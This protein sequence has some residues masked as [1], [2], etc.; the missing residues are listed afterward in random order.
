MQVRRCSCPRALAA[1]SAFA[2]ATIALAIGGC[3][4][5]AAAPVAPRP[6]T[7]AFEVVTSLAPFAS[8]RVNSTSL[9]IDPR[10][11]SHLL[12]RV[13]AALSATSPSGTL[14]GQ[15][16]DPSAFPVTSAQP[17]PSS[18]SGSRVSLEPGRKRSSFAV[19]RDL[20]STLH[21]DLID[22]CRAP[23]G[24]ILPPESIEIDFR[25]D[26]LGRIERTSVRA[27][28][29]LPAHEPAARCMAR[30]IRASDARFSSSLG[31]SSSVIHA[32]VPSED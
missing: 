24:D 6:S 30:V 31:E 4:D 5:D 1:R 13:P 25:V 3:T 12:A 18:T 2:Y 26:S 9:P 28:A 23:G 16:V 15:E 32:L 7:S 20:R 10:A 17:A 21:F 29:K 22:Q 27:V 19:E 11:K 14:V 8:T